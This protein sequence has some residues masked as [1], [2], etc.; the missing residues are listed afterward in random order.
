MFDIYADPSFKEWAASYIGS[1]Q[2]GSSSDIVGSARNVN[3]DVTRTERLPVDCSQWPLS[4]GVEYVFL[5]SGRVQGDPASTPAFRAIYP[6]YIGDDE[7]PLVIEISP[8]FIPDGYAIDT[9]PVEIRFDDPL[10]YYDNSQKP[11]TARGIDLGPLNRFDSETDFV[12]IEYMLA[13]PSRLS[14]YTSTDR[15]GQNTNLISVNVSN[16][17]P[18]AT[19]FAFKPNIC[20]QYKNNR[21]Y[22]LSITFER[23]TTEDGISGYRVKVPTQWDGTSDKKY[24]N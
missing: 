8:A 16:L 20:D 9:L 6:V 23:I 15:I 24:S 10:Y 4:P 14:F 12:S 5:T 1:L 22:P 2:A 19:G 13:S 11:A 18:V 3:I 21:S 7:G 17:S